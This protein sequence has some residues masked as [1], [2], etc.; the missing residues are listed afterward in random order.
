MAHGTV[1]TVTNMQL[2]LVVT[3]LILIIKNVSTMNPMLVLILQLI[4]LWIKTSLHQRIL[5]RYTH[6]LDQE[7]LLLSL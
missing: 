7:H 4:V 3:Q 6:S 2:I 5:P 1:N